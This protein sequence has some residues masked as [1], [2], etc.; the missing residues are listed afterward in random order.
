VNRVN[1]QHEFLL[2]FLEKNPIREPRRVDEQAFESRPEFGE[3]YYDCEARV[4]EHGFRVE[5][6]RNAREERHRERE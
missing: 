1:N 4:R 5:E 3:P 6:R 2:D